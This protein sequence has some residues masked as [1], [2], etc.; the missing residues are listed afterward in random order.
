MP[1][2]REGQDWIRDPLSAAAPN[3]YLAHRDSPGKVLDFYELSRDDMSRT[4]P[5]LWAEVEG[6]EKDGSGRF[7]LQYSTNDSCV[8]VTYRIVGGMR[9]DFAARPLSREDAYRISLDQDDWRITRPGP[10]IFNERHPR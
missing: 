5:D 7:V 3:D 4:T 1:L 8:E 9:T 10:R 6:E 2:R